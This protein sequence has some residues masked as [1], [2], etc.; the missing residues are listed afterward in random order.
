M[1]FWGKTEC[2]QNGQCDLGLYLCDDVFPD[3]GTEGVT[4]FSYII[5]ISPVWKNWRP[6]WAASGKPL[7]SCH[8]S[9]TRF[10]Y[11][12]PSSFTSPD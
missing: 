1:Q 8:K 7:P 9:P 12:L 10:W 4:W 6:V 3:L 11:Y 2:L 5:E